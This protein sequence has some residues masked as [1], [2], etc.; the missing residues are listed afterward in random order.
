MITADGYSKGSA[1]MRA[2]L[3]RAALRLAFQDGR[4]QRMPIIKLFNPKNARKGFLEPAE[5]EALTSHMSWPEADIA[6]LLH[7]SGWRSAEV[8]LLKWE[9]VDRGHNVIALEDTKN[10]DGRCIEM[11]GEIRTIIDQAWA[12]R[13]CGISNGAVRLS[14]YVVHHEGQRVTKTTFLRHWH[15]ACKKG[16][17]GHRIPHDLRRS[18]ARDATRAGIDPHLTMRLG[19]W[20]SMATFSRY[21]IIDTKQTSTVLDE[22]QAFRSNAGRKRT[23]QGQ[24]AL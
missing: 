16:G 23:L 17:L 9:Q 14:E 15:R 10:D 21:N 20:R 1:V 8:R 13:S 12:R 24:N 6:R 4:L 22:L 19:G 2:G 3:L 7:A 5:V 18:M 11:R